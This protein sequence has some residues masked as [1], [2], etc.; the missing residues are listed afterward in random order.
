MRK[1]TFRLAAA[2]LAFCITASLFPPVGLAAENEGYFDLTGAINQADSGGTVML[3]KDAMIGASGGDDDPWIIPKNVTID[4]QG[5]KIIL[6]KGG[7]LLGG[8][9]TIQNAQLDFTTDRKS[10]V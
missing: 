9:V 8:D 5:H 1:K 10:V 6:W 3:T 4:G 7:V 2:L